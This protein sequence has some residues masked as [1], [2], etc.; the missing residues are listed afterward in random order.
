MRHEGQ[1]GRQVGRPGWPCCDT[2]EGRSLGAGLQGQAPNHLEL[3]WSKAR[4]VSV[5][6]EARHDASGEGQEDERK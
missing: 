2:D 4:V 3:L 6:E 1:S 5:G